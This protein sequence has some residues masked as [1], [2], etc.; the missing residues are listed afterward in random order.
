MG[1]AANG[2]RAGSHDTELIHWIAAKFSQL[3]RCSRA[4]GGVPLE[5]LRCK[6]KG[7][8][9][10][11]DVLRLRP[12]TSS[13]T[14]ETLNPNQAAA[15]QPAHLHAAESGRNAHASAILNSLRFRQGCKDMQRTWV[16][17]R[18]AAAPAHQVA[19][20]NQATERL[21]VGHRRKVACA[22]A[23]TS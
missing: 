11:Q 14:N 1:D 9:K 22:S 7:D 4:G 23:T 16:L 12:H 8:G 15:V 18:A 21:Q 20:E 19:S 2:S 3:N 6:R 5:E 13:G 17:G 10:H